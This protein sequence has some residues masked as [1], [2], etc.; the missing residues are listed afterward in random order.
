M[1]YLLEDITSARSPTYNGI[2]G[3]FPIDVWLRVDGQNSS[4]VHLLQLLLQKV[5]FSSK[6]VII[7]R[8]TCNLPWGERMA[9]YVQQSLLFSSWALKEFRSALVVLNTSA[10]GQN[11]HVCFKGQGILNFKND[12]HS[13]CRPV[14]LV[15]LCP[16]MLS[17]SSGSWIACGKGMNFSPLLSKSF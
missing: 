11:P 13:Q 9:Q 3:W 5:G 2:S 17:P 16:F 7:P 1:Q 10:W 8:H 15:L 12:F 4:S 6:R 14:C